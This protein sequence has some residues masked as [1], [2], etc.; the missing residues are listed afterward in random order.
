MKR[1]HIESH[2][3]PCLKIA[4]LSGIIDGGVRLF[5]MITNIQLKQR[6]SQIDRRGIRENHEIK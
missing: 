6:K 4:W 5:S 2:N 3:K 1:F